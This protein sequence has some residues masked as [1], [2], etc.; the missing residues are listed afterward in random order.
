M[1]SSLAVARRAALQARAAVR[2]RHYANI[3][4]AETPAPT[5][6][7]PLTT[8]LPDDGD[9][10]LGDYPRLPFVSKQQRPARGWEDFQFRRNFGEPLHEQEE[11]LSV[12]GPDVPVVPG[13]TALRWFSIAALGFVSFG[14]LVNYVHPEIPAVRREYPFS[15]LVSELG[16]LEANKAREEPDNEADE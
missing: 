13:P 10:Q 12:W 14:V 8:T 11:V 15:G 9:P 4:A 5:T 3:T 2:V 6:P 16:S 7:A 1:S